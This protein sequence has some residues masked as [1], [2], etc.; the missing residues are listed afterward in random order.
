LQDL[1]IEIRA[2]ILPSAYDESIVLRVLN[3]NSIAVALRN[4]YAPKLLENS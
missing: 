3:P 2:S 1:E 4:G